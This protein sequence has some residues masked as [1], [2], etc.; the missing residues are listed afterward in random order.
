MI[1]NLKSLLWNIISSDLSSDHNLEAL[2]KIF[3]LNL[4]FVLGSISLISLCILRFIQQNFILSASNLLIFLFLACLFLYLRKTKKVNLVG[5][6]GTV[7]TGVFFAFL[8]AHGGINK[9]AYIW[10]LTYP[11]ISLF[12]LGIKMGTVTSVS[13]L[14]IACIIFTL[15]PRYPFLTSYSNDFI[16][17]FIL[18]YITIHLF[19]LVMEKVREMIQDKLNTANIELKKANRKLAQEIED[20]LRSEQGLR[21]SEKKFHSLFAFS[22]QAIAITDI[23]SGRLIDVNTKFCELTKYT[24]QEIL[25]QTTTA[26][27]FITEEWRA[28]FLNELI[29]KGEIEGLELEI[30]DRFGTTLSALT[31]SKIIKLA[32]KDYII[33]ICLDITERKRLEIQ[34]RQAQK[35][36]AIGT[37]AGGIAHDFNNL[38]MSIQ[39]KASVM[40]YNLDKS[41][42]LYDQLRSVE[43]LIQ[44]GSKVTN[45][46]LGFARE[47]KFEVKPTDLNELIKN[48]FKMFGTAR[49]EI[50]IHT[51]FEENIWTVE[52]D[53]NQIDQVL[54][55]LFVNASQAMPN[56]GDL[57]IKTENIV[58]DKAY[59]KPHLVQPG[60]FVKVSV[61]DTGVGMDESVM[62]KAF[63]PFF[64]TREVGQGTG[65][66][67]ASAYGII[68]N[69]NGFINVNSEKGVGSTF[70]IY[71]PAIEKHVTDEI[72]PT[73]RI[74]KGTGT[75]LLIDDEDR[76][77]KS[78]RE[79][80]EA[81]D[82]T[83]L[84]AANGKDGIQAYQ[85][86]KENINL[87]ILDMVLPGMNGSE[88]YDRLKEINPDV[89]V[90]L[91]SGYSQNGMAAEILNKGCNGF[92]QKPFTLE[93][94][95]QKIYDIL[96][97]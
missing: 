65:L 63:D 23:E 55:N 50:K 92:I 82:Y 51:E 15:G 89:K 45:Q 52:I 1:K 17:L 24:K 53:H 2:R 35:M 11:L 48:S 44:S 18:A 20:H 14:G 83:V 91:S 88:I 54:L 43:Q 29:S 12:L 86:N 31:F 64:T 16:L 59:V 81:L 90:L 9:T 79:M 19:A 49:K 26:L 7:S 85:E 34:L 8:I 4:L 95:S 93:Q 22:P 84:L 62:E 27:D 36:E 38:L 97:S 30:K 33:T 67:L 46:I 61:T 41:H 70:S 74:K 58:L 76:V 13:L 60:K 73:D 77:L 5:A 94:I 87:V 47:G 69:H 75:I 57:Y 96:H 42:G 39:G 10:S 71:L 68:K 37:L 32:G 3:M 6:I 56:G 78:G 21:E 80:L 72:K 28:K 25:G 66:G 40:L